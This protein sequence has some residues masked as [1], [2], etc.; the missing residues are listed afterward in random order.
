MILLV[1]I[2]TCLEARKLGKVESGFLQFF[3]ALLVLEIIALSL[4]A[5]CQ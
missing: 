5:L 4:R 2:L 3:T 1:L